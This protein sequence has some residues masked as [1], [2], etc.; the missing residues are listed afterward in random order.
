MEKSNKICGAETTAS[1]EKKKVSARHIYAFIH[2]KCVPNAGKT[3]LRKHT[4]DSSMLYGDLSWTCKRRIFYLEQRKPYSYIASFCIA[5]FVVSLR[6]VHLH[7]K[8]D[9]YPSG[10]GGFPSVSFETE[11]GARRG[12]GRKGCGNLSS[13]VRGEWGSTGYKASREDLHCIALRRTAGTRI[14]SMPRWCSR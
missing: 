14:A 13:N 2:V 9:K 12:R 8:W 11:S 10:R 3:L 4:A 7:R 6:A 1:K 5:V